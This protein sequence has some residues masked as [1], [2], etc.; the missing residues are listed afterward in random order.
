M[1]NAVSAFFSWQFIL[2]SLA[3]FAAVWTLRTVLEYFWPKLDGN[4]LWEKLILPISP[5]VFGT[6]IAYVSTK[7]A[8]PDGLSSLSGRLMFGSVAGM[9]SGLVYQVVKGMLKDKIQSVL[10]STT[11]DNNAPTPPV[12]PPQPD[13]PT[14]TTGG[15]GTGNK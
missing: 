8:Y 11:S 7:Y 13:L 2:F 5:V 10:N 15:M 6:L 3:V 9:F 4:N 12:Q 14:P 1:D